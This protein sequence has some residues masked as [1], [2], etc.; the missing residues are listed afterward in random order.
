MNAIPF[1][2]SPPVSQHDHFLLNHK[3][4]QVAFRRLNEELRQELAMVVA[5]D[6]DQQE[7]ERLQ[8]R[9]EQFQLEYDAPDS[10]PTPRSLAATLRRRWRQLFRI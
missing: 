1:Y 6:N 8:N 3:R 5:S 4:R 2:P 10:R 7:H 9:T